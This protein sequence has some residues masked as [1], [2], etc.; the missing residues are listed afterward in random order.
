MNIL[1][2]LSQLQVT[3]A[4]VY[5]VEIANRLMKKGHNLFFVSDTLT[6]KTDA[7]FIE[8]AFNKRNPLQRVGHVIKLIR[9]IKENKIDLIHAHSRASAWSVEIACKL[10]NT[11]FVTSIHGMQH[12]SKVRK[13]KQPVGRGFAV[14]ENIRDDLIQS[15]DVP[16]ESVEVLRNGIDIDKFTLSASP[17]NTKKVISIIG[18]LSGPKGE[19]TYQLL[20]NSIDLDKFTVNVVGGEVIPEKFKTFTGKVNFT[21]YVDNV[22]EY[23]KASDLVI[24]AGRVAIESLLMG[25]PT[26]AIGEAFEIGV[27][28]SN[29][30]EQALISNFG[31]VGNRQAHDFDWQNIRAEIARGI[32]LQQTDISV[33]DMIKDNYNLDHIVA[34]LENV[35]QHELVYTRKRDIPVIMYHRVIRDPETES[36]KHGTYVTETQ[37]N[38]HLQILSDNNFIPIT[39]ADIAKI[40]LHK[41]FEKKYIILTLDDGYED[42][43]TYAFPILKKFSF[44]AVIYL[45]S[46]IS[47]NQWDVT[48]TQEKTFKLM[49]QPMLEEL[50]ASGLIEFGGHTLTHPR[51]SR[52]TEQQIEHEI[53]ADKL[54]TEERLNIKLISF[55]YPYGDL[56]ERVKSVVD[57]AGYEFAVAT[58]SGSAALSDD[59]LQIRRIAIFPSITAFGFKRKI[60]GNYNF[61]KIKRELKKLKKKA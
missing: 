46:N 25:R 20:S 11:A 35:Y 1:M 57:E 15:F 32:A 3:G 36:G 13:R 16:A 6:K 12:Q 61:I 56:D 40:P 10:T 51:L 52:L 19:I 4:E 34:T 23:I 21:G 26:L 41:R 30:I 27:I 59:L 45:V 17:A 49:S 44:K 22:L 48:L 14:C 60:K 55:A 58:D 53:I 24:G 8:L 31:D 50:K 39:F 2:A 29:N 28:D 38:E 37:F 42:N 33:I 18:R 9:I 47:H 54:K 5:A 43:Y 7:K